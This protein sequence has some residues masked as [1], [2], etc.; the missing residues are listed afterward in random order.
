MMELKHR[1]IL[2]KILKTVHYKYNYVV[3]A[4]R[5]V[6][7]NLATDS[8]VLLILRPIAHQRMTL[9]TRGVVLVGYTM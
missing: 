3:H 2:S 5:N 6:D 8:C 1:V 9:V 4:V 7:P